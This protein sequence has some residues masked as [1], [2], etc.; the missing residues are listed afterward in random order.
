MNQY[1]WNWGVI[2]QGVP[3]TEEFYYQWLLSGL[4]WTIAT[5]LCAWVIALVIGTLVGVGRTVPNKAVAGLTTAYVELFRNV[6]LIVQMFLW[7]FVFPEFLPDAAGDWVKQSMPLPEFS[8]AVIALGFYTSARVAEQVRTG[9]LTLSR[10]QKNAGLALGLT[11]GQT[12]R[13]VML[14]MAFRIIVPPL[15]SE[16]MNIF[17][18][19]AVAL[20]IG[21]T[22][23]TFQMRQM[24]GEYAPANPIE[25]MTYT[26]LLYLIVAF[27]VN[28]I[29]ALVEKKVQ[30][31]GY[32]GGGK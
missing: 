1:Q 11:L 15:T 13:Y 24:T 32:I 25:V 17:K 7:F 28:R 20:A 9:I 21:L 4:G 10:G 26:S 19:S 31:P 18:N 30:V 16:F 14:P 8:T 6:P 29:M 22:E 3:D 12:Y 5:A 27:S 23:L 2:L